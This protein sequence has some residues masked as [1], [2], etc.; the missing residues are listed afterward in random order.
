[1]ATCN[2]ADVLDEGTRLSSTHTLPGRHRGFDVLNVAAAPLLQAT[3]FLKF[4]TNQKEPPEA[5]GIVVTV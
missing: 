1:M 2:L 4:H 3:E 5:E